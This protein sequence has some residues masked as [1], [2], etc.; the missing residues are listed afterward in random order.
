VVLRPS[1]PV[2]FAA[3]LSVSRVTASSAQS[4]NPAVNVLDGNLG[5]R[6][7]AQ[8]E[9]QWAQLDLGSTRAVSEVQIA[10]Q[11]GSIRTARFEV[12]TSRDGTS[13]TSTIPRTSSSGKTTA[14]ESYP[15]AVVPARY[16]RVVGHGNS[17]NDWISITELRAT[18]Y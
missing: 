12:Q 9:G 18:G 6:W 16:L 5:T 17:V 10:W 2:S 8:G 15:V 11:D 3:P 14:L 7:S 1:T 13:W 4:Q